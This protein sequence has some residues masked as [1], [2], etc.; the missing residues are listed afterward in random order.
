VS[1]IHRRKKK[2]NRK[3]TSIS[4]VGRLITKQKGPTSTETTTGWKLVAEAF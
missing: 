2:Q 1:P 3:T 4:L